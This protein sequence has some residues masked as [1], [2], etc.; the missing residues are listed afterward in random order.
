[1][2]IARVVDA[3]GCTNVCQGRLIVNPNPICTVAPPTNEV[4]AGLS[5][6]FTASASS[7]TAPYTFTWTGPGG[8][9][10]SGPSIT[11]NNAQAANAGVYYA[12]VVD[13]KGC[14]N[15]CQGRLIVNPRGAIG[16]Y[17]WLDVNTNGCQE[18]NEPPVANVTVV[19]WTCTAGAP[20]TRVATNVTDVNGL[21]LFP[22]LCAGQYAVQ[23]I[24]P[25]EY[26]G[27][28]RQNGCGTPNDPARDSDPDPT[29]GVAP[30]I[31][32]ASGE[33][34]RT[35]DAGLTLLACLGDYVWED[36]NRDGLQNDGNTGI[37]NVTVQLLP[38]AGTTVLRTV[39]TDP[40]GY[41]LFCDLVPGSYRVRVLV[42]GGYTVTLQNQG[43]NDC[44]DSDADATGL[45]DCVTLAPGDTNLCTDIGLFRPA[46]LGDYVWVDTNTNGIQ[47]EVGT[48]KAGVPVELYTCAGTLLSN[49]VTDVQG[50]YLFCGLVPG[51]YKVRFIL[52]AG[53]RFTTQDAGGDDCRDSD[54]DSAGWTVCEI[55]VSGETNLCYDA[56][57]VPIPPRICVTKDVTCVMPDPQNPGQLVVCD[58]NNYRDRAVGV[59]AQGTGSPEPAFCY[60]ITICN[61]GS[62]DLTN[63]TVIDTNLPMYG[64]PPGD[65]TEY[66]FPGGAPRVLPLGACI[67]KWF[68]VDWDESITN[69]VTARGCSVSEPQNC[70]STND[71]AVVEILPARLSCET[72][73]T[74]NGVAGLADCRRPL[75]LPESSDTY[76]LDFVVKVCNVGMADLT[77]VVVQ[78]P[79]ALADL[80]CQGYTIP[81][82]ARQGQPGDCA[83]VV[84]CSVPWVCQGPTNFGY[85]AITAEAY[86]GTNLLCV[87]DI[88]GRLITVTNAD[89]A[90]DF[91]LD[92]QAAGCCRVTGG[93]K[94]L[95]NDR[96]NLSGSY[97]VWDTYTTQP[98]VRYVTHGG[99]VGAPVSRITDDRN[100]TNIVEF[101]PDSECIHGRW[102]HVRHMKGGLQGNFHATSFDSLMCACLDWTTNA[103]NLSPAQNAKFG[104]LCN[105]DS[106]KG[107]PGPEPRPAPAN[108]IT[109]TGVGNYAEPNG[110]REGRSVL[111]RVDIEDRS[112]PGGYHPGGQKP[113]PDRYRIRIWQLTD[114]ELR[115]LNDPTDKLCDMRRAI[116]A[117]TDNVWQTDGALD[118]AGKPVVN[119]TPV[120]GLRQPNVDDG[121]ALTHGNHQLHPAVKC[122]NKP[123]NTC[124]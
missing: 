120:F 69:Q 107:G 115:R 37:P 85:V 74:T 29:T 109:F 48:G 27:F 61:C 9:T 67:T 63:V 44:L 18:T 58:D 96:D 55:L 45:T 105:A 20:T 112:E 66:F 80:G 2:Y 62:V 22:D 19:L 116:A 83:L 72:C 59:I 71:T 17:V 68:A 43:A 111:F 65:L 56:G 57:L 108:K 39:Q 8:F 26:A 13:A 86:S 94:Q 34:N 98:P 90:C 16:D 24:K 60:R 114:V 12:R 110:R 15:V 5:A 38:C 11:I 102:T 79:A 6:T 104:Q 54:A 42:P 32:L 84:L 81:F 76:L 70:V 10:A 23:F 51:S 118:A 95:A 77:N 50:Y 99:Q 36:M 124:P 21:Y 41:Y 53:Y 89:T 122:C 106:K 78:P 31:T 49:T 64:T 93:G 73:I 47:D 119:G 113:P 7:G 25:P 52:P 14:T 97:L 88:N 100:T 121:G 28:T 91:E 123:R 4:C 103:G 87:Y 33:T 101:D 40:Q 30:C 35:V 82:L 46:C 75:I 1:L 3:K 117:S 92:C